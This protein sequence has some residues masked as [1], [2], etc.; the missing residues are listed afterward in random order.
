M[1][2]Q[3]VNYKP[4][5]LFSGDRLSR[6]IKW[7]ILFSGLTGFIVFTDPLSPLPLIITLIVTFANANFLTGSIILVCIWFR[8]SYNTSKQ[9]TEL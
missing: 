3:L 9:K 8:K 5:K 6:W 7:T 2:T 4:S 1:I